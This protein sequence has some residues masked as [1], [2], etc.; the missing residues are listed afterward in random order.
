MQIKL[1]KRLSAPGL[2]EASRLRFSRIPDPLAGKTRYP[3]EQCLMSALAMFSLKYP[4]LLQFEQSQEDEKIRHNLKTLYGV[5]QAPSDTYMRQ[6]LDPVEPA[7][8]R[9]AFK[10][11]FSAVQRGKH[12]ALYTF[13]DDYYLV[14][15]DGTGFFHS[16]KVHCQNCCVKKHRKGGESYYHQMMCAVMVHPNQSVVLP[17]A[18]EPILKPDGGS[19]NDCERNASK[20][21][22]SQ[23]RLMH[24]KLKMVIVE[25]AL[26]SNAPHL[27]Q[28]KL[29][30]YEY[31]IGVKPDSH[32]WLFDWVNAGK[33]HQCVQ[34]RDGKTYQFRWF[35][36]AP[37]NESH[38]QLRV[39]FFECIETS[40]RGKVQKF[41]WITGFH[42]T[43]GNV[44][45]LM[46]GARARWKIENETFN[47]L[48]TQGYHFEHNYGHGYENLSTVLGHL[49]M[50]A[51]L[52]DQIQLLCCPQFRAALKKC[53]KRSRLW[54]RLRHWF[55]TFM[56]DSWEAFF[57]CIANP[58]TFKLQ[59]ESG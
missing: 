51:F 57:H 34:K 9:S 45:E 2:L 27:E 41:T 16:E 19:K 54:E 24:P 39:N 29:L 28:L 21:L 36:D 42:I 43:E 26:H 32:A 59:I 4:S 11:C 23:L 33:S 7:K 35:N 50:L 47:T 15:N 1:K 40:E 38:E 53:K 49:M 52:I 5:E 14:S 10:A 37:L 46:K 25:D 8:L 6:R 55:L 17:L 31:I 20:R 44:Y 12:L 58:P 3:L 48:K 13:L 30:N 18:L 56:I 22:L